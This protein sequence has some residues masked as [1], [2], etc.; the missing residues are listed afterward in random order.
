MNRRQWI[1]ELAE[2]LLC[3]VALTW[4]P[5]A[6]GETN[7]DLKSAQPISP[8]TA[9]ASDHETFSLRGRVVWLADALQQL[10]G[11]QTVPEARDR[12]LVLQTDDGQLHP[13]VEDIRGRGIRRDERFRNT[14]CE[15]LVRR[16]N[17]SPFVQVIRFFA[18]RQDGKYELDYWCEIC[19]IATFETKP[20][21]CCQG[22]V[23]LRE[24][25]VEP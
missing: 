25:R 22:P 24:R 21:E 16:R 19:A 18:V 20:C 14:P 17:G 2:L 9:A 12:V 10:H 15:L 7:R 4:L 8:S 1:A 23:E 6:A 11:I 5:R 3:G 13:L